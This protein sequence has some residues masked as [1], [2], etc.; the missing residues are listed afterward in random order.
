MD[1]KIFVPISIAANCMVEYDLPV[2][3][4]EAENFTWHFEEER[5]GKIIFQI[6]EPMERRIS[7]Y[8]DDNVIKLHTPAYLNEDHPG[9]MKKDRKATAPHNS[10]LEWVRSN[11]ELTGDY[12]G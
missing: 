6:D 1:S 2:T 9:S 10:A 3:F 5:N 12:N 4:A 8:P 7:V 11:F